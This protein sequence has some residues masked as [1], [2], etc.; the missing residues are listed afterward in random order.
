MC[1][2]LLA[3]SGFLIAAVATLVPVSAQ[4]PAPTPAELTLRPGDT[5]TWT[6]DPPHRVRFGGSVAHGGT[7]ALTPFAEVEKIL[8][9]TPKLTAGSDGIARAGTGEKVTATVKADADKAGVPEFFFTCGFPAHPDIMVTVSFKIA[10]AAGQPA[11]DVRISPADSGTPRWL[12]HTTP[13]NAAGDRKLT[14]P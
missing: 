14:R 9:I 8:D 5:I 12:L 10:A 7:L 2:M 6:P 3:V 1:K 4:E 13:G 11:R